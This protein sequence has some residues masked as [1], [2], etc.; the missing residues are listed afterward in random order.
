MDSW[1]AREIRI[2]RGYKEMAGQNPGVNGQLGES[3]VQVNGQL[4][5]SLPGQRIRGKTRFITDQDIVVNRRN[6]K[7]FKGVYWGADAESAPA[8]QGTPGI[9]S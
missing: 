3:W 6:P 2:R 5:W 1:K 4:C 9:I 8:R 7:V